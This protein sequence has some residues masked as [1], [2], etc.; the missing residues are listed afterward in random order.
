M[1]SA[2]SSA[3]YSKIPS[4][5]RKRD[6]EMTDKKPREG[7]CDIMRRVALELLEY[8]RCNIKIEISVDKLTK[9]VIINIVEYNIQ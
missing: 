2:K 7:P 9:S 8:Y 6:K 4:S 5:W 3:T 1:N